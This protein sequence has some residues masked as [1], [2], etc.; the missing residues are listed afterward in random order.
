MWKQQCERMMWPHE[1]REPWLASHRLLL[2]HRWGGGVEVK[3]TSCLHQCWTSICVNTHVPMN[4]INIGV[5]AST[6]EYQN[7]M[8]VIYWYLVGISRWEN[9]S[10][11]DLLPRSTLFLM[12]RRFYMGMKVIWLYIDPKKYLKYPYPTC[13]KIMWEPCYRYPSSI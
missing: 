12:L 13:I 4:Y 5:R 9:L 6:C 1:R 3:V 8:Q 2:D 11:H 7:V 10:I